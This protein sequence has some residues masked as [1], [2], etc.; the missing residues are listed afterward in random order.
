LQKG[1]S[2]A[3]VSDAGT[4]LISDPG[5]ALVRRARATGIPVM[6]VPGPCAAI[7]ALSVSGLP[8]DRF[9]FAGF[10]PA[11]T[12]A[13]RHSLETLAGESRTVVFYESTHRIEDSLRSMVEVLGGDRIICLA[14]ELTKLH[15]ESRTATAGELLEW[16]QA[17]ADR[18]RGEF[19]LVVQGA[20][21]ADGDEVEAARVLKVLLP[22]VG[23]ARA[24][25][26]AAQLT[27]LPRKRLYDLAWSGRRGVESRPESAEQS[28]PCLHGG[29]KSGLPGQDA[30]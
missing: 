30:S 8:V 26:L 24:A 5:F 27:G 9:I 12:E 21:T 19:V 6:A 25:K 20:G 17:D 28:L 1:R 4:P 10:L 2:V 15:E 11:K 23:T 13:R 3:L 16:V 14:R 29:G 22:E 7:A 18:Q